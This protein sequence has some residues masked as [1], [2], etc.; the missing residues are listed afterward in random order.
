M[1][2]VGRIRNVMRVIKLMWLY[3]NA[4]SYPH[5]AVQ[6]SKAR[7]KQS[8]LVGRQISLADIGNKFYLIKPPCARRF[9]SLSCSLH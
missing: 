5:D 8:N 6:A 9:Q 3:D 2:R 1:K 4:Q 7:P